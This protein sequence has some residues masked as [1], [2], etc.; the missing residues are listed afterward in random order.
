M[1]SKNPHVNHNVIPT[2]MFG[3]REQASPISKGV[4]EIRINSHLAREITWQH[5]T[6]GPR[7]QHEW[8][9][10]TMTIKEPGLVPP[11][12]STIYHVKTST[13]SP[14]VAW[15]LSLLSSVKRGKLSSNSAT[16]KLLSLR[17]PHKSRMRQYKIK[18]YFNRAQPTRSLIDTGG[19][20][21]FRAPNMK[22][23]HS[24]PFH[25][26]FSTFP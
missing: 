14:W 22:I 3:C 19:A 16:V 5:D 26:V 18:A 21:T 24:H 10:F 2:S 23:D 11:H 20:T 25:P 8:P 6:R 15:T 1:S 17:N 13:S 9:P 7:R 12:P 4:A